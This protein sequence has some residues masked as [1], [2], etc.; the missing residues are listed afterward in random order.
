MA[1]FD[2]DKV[3]RAGNEAE[4]QFL[5][6]GVELLATGIIESHGFFDVIGVGE[7]GEGGGLGGGG[8]IEGLTRFL[9]DGGDGGVGEAVAD[10]KGGKALD[11]GEGTE[12]DDGAALLDP[13]DRGGRFGEEFV[14]GFVQDKEGA[15]GKFFNEGGQFGVGDAGAGGVIG[16]G[17]EDEA[18]VGREAGG[19]AG[20]VVM[21]IAI[22]NL[23]KG[24]SE[25]AG[26]ESINGEG[27][28]G[29]EN[30]ALARKC[31][32]VVA[33]F[34]DFVGAA[35]EDN[36]IG[37]EA[38]EFGDGLAEG[39]A[40]A[41]G[42]KVGEIERVADGLQSGGGGAEGI[43]VRGELGNLGRVESVFAGDIG[44]GATWFVRVEVGDVGIGDRELHGFWGTE[45]VWRVRKRWRARRILGWVGARQAAAKRAAL[46][47]PARP[48]AKKG[49]GAEWPSWRRRERLRVGKEAVGTRSGG[50]RL[51]D[52]PTF[53][54]K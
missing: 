28:G 53:P 51:G 34:D 14:V 46:I 50:M 27:V 39:E 43:F 7:P 2:H 17:E 31:V 45:R 23:C 1:D 8:G 44:D 30:A 54:G 3:G 29:G 19:E 21:E 32:S 52:L 5:E 41:V 12:N 25:E 48:A 35:T 4:I 47:W 10:A 26:H 33:K 24:N 49:P 18:N 22:R 36:V 20:E 13:L 11:F 6:K 37:G 15:F 42:V 40:G 38:V 9:Q 16:G